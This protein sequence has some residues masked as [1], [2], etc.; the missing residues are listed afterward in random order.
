MGQ[1]INDGYEA[2]VVIN[3]PLEQV[4]KTLQRKEGPELAWLQVWPRFAGF[5]KTATVIEVEDRRRIRVRKDSEPCRGSEILIDLT[6]ETDTTRIRVIQSSLP[7]W[8]K[9]AIDTFV[10]GGDQ[11]VADLV[12]LLERDVLVCR[13]S[14][15]WIVSG[16]TA[17]EVDSGLEVTSVMDGSFADK[18][19]L[20]GGDLLLTFGGA[21]VFTQ[22]GLQTLLRVF[23]TGD[24]VELTWVRGYDLQR[25]Q[26][27]V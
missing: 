2:E 8:V 24:E 22:H 17:R 13:H 4:W 20:E 11:I 7:D 19:G 6:D 25:G 9:L 5:D 1:Y 14:M 27:K 23:K 12:L 15:R 21:P 18:V 10:L 16:F 26:A 3:Q